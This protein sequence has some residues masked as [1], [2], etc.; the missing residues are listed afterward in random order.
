MDLL[1]DSEKFPEDW[2]FKHR[3]AKGKK[4][5]SSILPSGEK[6]EF[7]TVG[8]RTSAVVPAIQKKTGPGANEGN[9][10][11]G[12]NSKRKRTSQKQEDDSEVDV[13]NQPKKSEPKKR[14]KLK[15]T[16]K[17]EEEGAASGRRRSSRV[18]K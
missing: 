12:S 13:E 1:G 3:W 8:G 9:H 16:A 14:N 11:K 17:V 18:K 15:K 2:L 10:S 4:N 7:V 5:Q 6:I